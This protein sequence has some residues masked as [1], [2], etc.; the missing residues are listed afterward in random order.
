MTPQVPIVGLR[1]SDRP[2]LQVHF[3]CLAAE[4]LR[5]RFG[6]AMPPHAIR[7]YVAR[8]DFVRDRLFAVQG[9]EG[10]LVAVA[11]VTL[12]NGVAQLGVTVLPGWRG[13]GLGSELV[14]RAMP[15]L[16]ASSPEARVP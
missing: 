8:I 4:D 11:H 2:Y 14:A 7:D 12:A 6:V 13:R 1:E 3:L 5:L 9:P 15:S 10:S 16:K